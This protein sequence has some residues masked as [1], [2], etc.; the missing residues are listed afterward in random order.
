M[1]ANCKMAHVFLAQAMGARTVCLLSIT[2]SKDWL[3]KIKSLQTKPDD[4][5][6]LVIDD[7]D[8]ADAEYGE[9]CGLRIENTGWLKQS[10]ILN[11]L[12][13]KQGKIVEKGK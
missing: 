9:I 3:A 5:K 7:R 10:L 11:F 12:A 13:N 1:S 4:F 2:Q 8:A 6:F